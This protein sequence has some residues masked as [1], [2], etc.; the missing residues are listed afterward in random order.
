MLIYPSEETAVIS[1]QETLLS[2]RKRDQAGVR[3]PGDTDNIAEAWV[4][5]Q[6]KGA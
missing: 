2:Q 1:E 5:V 6:F 4:R 3:R